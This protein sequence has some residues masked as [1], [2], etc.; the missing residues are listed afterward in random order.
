MKEIVI[1]TLTILITAVSFAQ[2]PK[3]DHQE[4]YKLNYKSEI[5][6]TLGLFGL[7]YYGYQVLDR[8]PTLDNLQIVSLDKNDVWAFDRKALTQG[9]SQRFYS[10]DISDLGLN[11]TLLLPVFLAL[12]KGIRRDWLDILIL[13]LETQAISSNV[14]VWSGP[15]LSKRIRPFVYYDE[16]PYDEK[17]V[18]GT[19]NSFFSGHTSLT[20]SASFFM[21]KVYSDYHPELGNKKF[22]FFAAALIPPAFVGYHRFRALK[23]FPTDILVGTAIGAAT[24]ILTPHFHKIVK[25]KN[26]NLSVVPFVG[27]YSGLVVSLKF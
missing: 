8:K 18:T 2:K 13:Y 24:G 27:A 19:T 3:S 9:T 7:N 10:Q 4:I 11:I 12:D 6:I 16:V 17:T 23:H 15:M 14:Y 22:L 5:P 1:W 20:A 26:E 25:S 21:A